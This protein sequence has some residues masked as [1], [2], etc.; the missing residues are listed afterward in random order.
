MKAFIKNSLLAG[1]IVLNP[2]T[3]SALSFNVTWG[4]GVTDA[5]KTAFQY[6]E[7]QFSNLFTNNINV[8]LNVNSGAVALGQTSQN[9][10]ITSYNGVSSAINAAY[11]SSLLSANSM[12]G[13]SILAVDGAEAKALGLNISPSIP[14]AT[15]TF[16]NTAAFDTSTTG[17][18]S[19]GKYSFVSVAEHE[20][21]EALGRIDYGLQS[22]NGSMVLMPLDLYRYTTAGVHS[23]TAG[24]ANA[25]FSMDGGR[26]ALQYFNTVSSKGDITDWSITSTLTNAHDAFNYALSPGVA[27]G[28]TPAD[29]KVMQALGY[30]VAAAVPE[31]EEWALM[32]V[33]L[34]LIGWKLRSRNATDVAYVVA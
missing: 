22:Y 13:N 30:T 5:E 16:S 14:D 2:V 3:A 28:I 23:Y 9:L 20:I 18:V 17:T 21:S 12:P 34:A 8:N 24:A 26:T 4:S 32:L 31:P 1:F 15:I 25:Y 29:I 19:S 10:Y 33:G 6:A 27:S 11:G 7:S